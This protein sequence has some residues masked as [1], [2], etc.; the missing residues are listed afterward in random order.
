MLFNT[1]YIRYNIETYLMYLIANFISV[2]KISFDNWASSMQS[3]VSS[4]H[5]LLLA[6]LPLMLTVF[7]LINYDRL[8]LHKSFK[9]TWGAYYAGTIGRYE[10]SKRKVAIYF[11]AA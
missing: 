11:P 1:F 7:Y 4:I 9:R 8:T 2:Q 10:D 3:L 6:V 5:L